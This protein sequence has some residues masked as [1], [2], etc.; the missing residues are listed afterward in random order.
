LLTS[1]SVSIAMNTRK[2]FQNKCFN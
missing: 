1:K 2:S